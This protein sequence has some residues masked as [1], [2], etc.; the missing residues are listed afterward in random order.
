MVDARLGDEEALVYLPLPSLVSGSCSE[1]RLVIVDLSGQ[2]CS[3]VIS[4]LRY[5]AHY[6]ISSHLIDIP[7]LSV[8]Y[9]FIRVPKS[10]SN[11]II[12]MTGNGIS[13]ISTTYEV[14]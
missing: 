9:C 13:G 6:I 11:Y 5:L 8:N 7:Y 10:I 14:L 1:H 4:P 12:I 2:K 3:K